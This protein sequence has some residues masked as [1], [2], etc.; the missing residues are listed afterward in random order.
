MRVS[1]QIYQS[2]GEI[3][4]YE[5]SHKRTRL[6]KDLK[7]SYWTFFLHA[8]ISLSSSSPQ[9]D[10]SSNRKS[11]MV[12]HTGEKVD[13]SRGKIIR[14]KSRQIHPTVL[15]EQRDLGVRQESYTKNKQPQTP[16]INVE[17]RFLSI[18]LR[19]FHSRSGCQTRWQRRLKSANKEEVAK[20]GA[21]Q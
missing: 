4:P 18:Y 2:L 14:N 5:Q 6:W 10:W 19:G 21:S 12:V 1:V 3:D 8:I 16:P 13:L 17:Q 15:Q 11:M 20:E 9:G 7:Q